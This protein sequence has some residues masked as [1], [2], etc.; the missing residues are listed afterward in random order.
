[1]KPT[2]RVRKILIYRDGGGRLRNPLRLVR[3]EGFKSFNN[4]G[5]HTYQHIGWES[6]TSTKIRLY[7]WM[8]RL[9]ALKERAYLFP[10]QKSV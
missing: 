6:R 9:R 4:R 10:K 7:R 5:S 1:M 8:T 3:E 2:C